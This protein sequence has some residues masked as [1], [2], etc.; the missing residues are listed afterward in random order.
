[1]KVKP[2]MHKILVI[3]D[4]YSLLEEI[5]DFLTLEGYD[6]VA[7]HH[8]REGVQMALEHV[9]DLIICDV[10]MPILDGYGVLNELRSNDE[11]CLIPFIFLTAKASQ[12]NLRYGMN[13]G[14]DDYITKPF[15][16]SDLLDA[17]RTRLEK[18]AQVAHKYEQRLDELRQS[19]VSTIPHELRTPLTNILGM[20]EMLQYDTESLQPDHIRSMA[21]VIVRAGYR[22]H[23]L[24]ENYIL[25][26][27][28][29]ILEKGHSRE[30]LVYASGTS[31]PS[32][33]IVDLAAHKAKGC[34]R[35]AD[36]VVDMGNDREI[37]IALQYLSKIAEELLDNAFK[38]S[39]PGTAVTVA[40]QSTAASF[41][42]SVTDQG[43]GMSPDQME[44]V[45]AF[46]Q[47]GREQ[48]E[49]Q[50]AGFGLAIAQRLAQLHGGDLRIESQLQQGTRVTV[51]IPFAQV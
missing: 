30:S 20:G 4:E 25:Y 16:S 29:H 7:A 1:M 8:G 27:Q 5:V 49:Q 47:F 28:L 39:E 34:G 14:A 13:L 2:R 22:L 24:I 9:P 51:A 50:G 3:E 46:V 43:R 33:V 12:Q 26:S 42:F 48:Y 6:P 18:H 17:V 32:N 40:T 15:S 19:L 41:V 31:Q 23:R 37:K 35:E 45:G 38:F 11:T 21:G 44:Q 36:L 10:M